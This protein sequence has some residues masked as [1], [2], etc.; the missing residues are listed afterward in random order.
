MDFANIVSTVGFPIAACGFMGWYCKYTLDK[1]MAM[2]GNIEQKYTALIKDQ[3]EVVANNTEALAVLT[4]RISY[5][6][7]GV[8]ENGDSE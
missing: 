3:Q 1:F 8:N 4:E 7:K 6:M 5:T 2:V